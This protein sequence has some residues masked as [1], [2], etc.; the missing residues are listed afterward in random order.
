MSFKN[1]TPQELALFAA[2]LISATNFTILLFINIFTSSLNW[3]ILI[4]VVLLTFIVG[5][6]VFSYALRRFI[7]RKIKIIYKAIH[8]LKRAKGEPSAKI[9][10]R[11]H[12]IDEVEINVF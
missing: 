10:L 8:R 12:I 9:D 6:L 5:Y 4:L 2:L 3:M 11:N 1:P 7:Y